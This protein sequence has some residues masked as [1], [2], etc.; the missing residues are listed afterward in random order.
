MQTSSRPVI[1]VTGSTGTIG[2]E[3]VRLLSQAA[4]PT[5]AL[6]RDPAK[7]QSLPG[8]AWV[9]ADLRDMSVLEPALA[10]T[11]HL[12]LLSNNEP[13]FAKLQIHALRVAE[14]LGAAHVVKLSALGASDHSK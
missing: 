2:Q 4:A 13:G 9:R 1:T 7:I 8:V 5:R 11:A 14:Q 6:F 10:G 3:L 12:F